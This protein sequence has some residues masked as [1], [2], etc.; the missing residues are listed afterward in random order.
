MPVAFVLI[1]QDMVP[2]IEGASLCVLT[3]HPHLPDN[4]NKTRD[5]HFAAHPLVFLDSVDFDNEMQD[6]PSL[7]N[8]RIHLVVKQMGGLQSACNLQSSK[9]IHAPYFP[10]ITFPCAGSAII[11]NMAVA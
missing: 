11:E 5:L 2:L 3:T 1:I 4:D 8:E 7:F 6:C 10:G 9:S